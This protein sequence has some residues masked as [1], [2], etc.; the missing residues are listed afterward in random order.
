MTS[1]T[2]R[3]SETH[4]F[5][6]SNCDCG[7]TSEP[8]AS[9]IIHVAPVATGSENSIKPISAAPSHRANCRPREPATRARRVT[10]TKQALVQTP[11]TSAV[12]VTDR[13]PR[14]CDKSL[15]GA[16]CLFGRPWSCDLIR[17]RLDTSQMRKSSQLRE[18]AGNPFV[19]RRRGE[20]S[21]GGHSAEHSGRDKMASC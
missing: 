5:G 17:R 16:Q 9:L 3:R 2:T 20:S 15:R 11:G 1:R 19:E 13:T 10:P 7:K 12:V 21:C 8:A 6:S 14:T 4:G 18:A